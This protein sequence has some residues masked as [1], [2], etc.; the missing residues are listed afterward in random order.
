MNVDADR[1]QTLRIERGWSQADLAHAAELDVRTIQRIESTGAASMRSKRALAA[2]LELDLNDLDT[3][4]PTMTPCP[5]CR[6]ER[7]FKCE[8][9][10][11]SA[12]IGGELLPKL[13]S[14][15]FSSAKM[16]AVVCA[17]CGL[18]RYFV[19]PDALSKLEASKHW[20]LA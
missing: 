13:A 17:D 16:R 4:E 1:I 14:G 10:I 20:T 3:K 12:T 7:V 19:E 11:D 8:R 18:L 6:S 15:A 9:T 2:A 5:H